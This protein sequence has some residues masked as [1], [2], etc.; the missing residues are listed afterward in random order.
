M[1]KLPPPRRRRPADP[2]RPGQHRHY[3]AWIA[4]PH[5]YRCPRYVR[6]G[7]ECWCRDP[8]PQYDTGWPWRVVPPLVTNPDEPAWFYDDTGP[9]PVIRP[10]KPEPK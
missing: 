5:N 1:R 3:C 7:R 2:V 9:H 10:A 8:H 6:T 4:N